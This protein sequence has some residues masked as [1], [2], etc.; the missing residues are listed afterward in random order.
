MK[1]ISDILTG[2]DN[3]TFDAARVV[4]VVGAFAYIAFWCVQVWQVRRFEPSDADAYGKGLGIVLLAMAGAVMLKRSTEPES[5]LE[6][7]EFRPSGEAEMRRHPQE[8]GPR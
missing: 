2:K 4:G 3:L 8:G 7:S 1:I 6:G 5:R